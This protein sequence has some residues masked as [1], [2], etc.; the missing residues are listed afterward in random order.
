[1]KLKDL[2][3]TELSDIW[4]YLIVI[5][6]VA[7]CAVALYSVGHSNG[8]SDAE[9]AQIAV[10]IPTPTPTITPT[11]APSPITY[12]TDVQSVGTEYGYVCLVDGNG[13]EYLVMNFD[14]GTA[15]LLHASYSGT[16]V[17]SYNGIPELENVA[18]TAYPDYDYYQNDD[19]HQI[20]TYTGNYEYNDRIYRNGYDRTVKCAGTMV[21]G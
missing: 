15:E 16:I 19:Y 20:R 5:G 2:G 21:C 14:P 17:G 1:M 4:R 18:L 6:V 7:F 10:P 8:L 12:I 13:K 11:P 3:E 9:S